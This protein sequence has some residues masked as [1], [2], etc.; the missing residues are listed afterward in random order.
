MHRIL[1]VD[2]EEPVGKSLQR[3]FRRKCFEVEFATDATAALVTIERFRPDFVIS[4]YRM[5]RMNGAELVREIS[6]RYPRIKCM[7]MSG[8]VGELDPTCES[9][10]FLS[11]PFN[12]ASLVERIRE[13]LGPR[14]R[15]VA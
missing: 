8:Y 11:K 6:V 4:D 1:I 2:D 13:I 10:E 5:P 14:V 15:A 3:A 9:C 12:T 7:I